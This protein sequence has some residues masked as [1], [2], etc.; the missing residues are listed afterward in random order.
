[1]KKHKLTLSAIADHFFIN[2]YPRPADF[3]WEEIIEGKK[4]ALSFS[5]EGTEPVVSGLFGNANIRISFKP[6]R[7]HGVRELIILINRA[8]QK[9]DSLIIPFDKEVLIGAL[10]GILNPSKD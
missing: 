9:F 8:Q 5:H 6:H 1:M 10:H 3:H 2:I 7:V 4:V